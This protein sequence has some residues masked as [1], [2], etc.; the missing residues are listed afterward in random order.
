MN[1]AHAHIAASIEA[2]HIV[3]L[4]LQLVGGAEK[5]LLAPDNENADDQNRHCC[6]D[7]NSQPRRSRH[8]SPT[9]ALKIP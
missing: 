5:I 3:E 1:A 4:R 7:E 6:Q 9:N 8:K 2:D